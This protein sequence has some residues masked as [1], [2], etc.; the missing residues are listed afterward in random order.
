MT[1]DSIYLDNAATSFPKADAVYD[2]VDSYQRT[3]GAAFGRGTRGTDQAD[4][5]VDRCRHRIAQLIGAKDDR[6]V[7]FTLNGT[8]GLNLLLRG[9]IQRGQH[10]ITTTLEHNSVLRP[11]EQLKALASI[12]VDH[13][14][15]ETHTGMVD[16]DRFT[17]ALSGRHPD[18]VVIN[19]V[20]NVTGV[21]QPLKELLG[22][23]RNAGALTM[24][25]ASQAVGH[26][27]IDVEATGI[28]LLA[29]PGHKGIGGPL[30]TGFLYVHPRLHC[31]FVSTR[32]GGT[33]TASESL[34]QPET[35]PELVESGNL[36]MPG[37]AGLEAALAW[38]QSQEF[39]E[40]ESRHHDQVQTLVDGLR[41]IDG[42]TIHAAAPASDRT[43][44]VSFNIGQC[45]P[46]EVAMIL[47][48]SFDIH[49]RAG[50]HCA[51]L[52]HRTLG[53]EKR[54]GTVRFSPGL[55]TTDDEISQAVNAVAS[56]AEAM[57]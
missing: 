5:L 24:V 1:G 34:T 44:V 47:N 52:V 36:N 51:P 2:A 21:I 31:Q 50:L 38:Q 15:F 33:G 17:S 22:A 10:V 3:S 35:M 32:C 8:D 16:P 41:N 48:Q 27:P 53:T 46:Q 18:L 30:G 54:G 37:I 13:V 11:L 4:S 28:D 20:S 40:L 14:P 19:A 12:T 23:A 55:F 25:D 9:V 57:A 45:E 49:C 26:V 7:A 43:G 6:C 39:A 42:L 56:I 29:A